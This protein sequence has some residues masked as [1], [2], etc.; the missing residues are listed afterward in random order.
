M[1]MLQMG[2]PA[3]AVTGEQQAVKQ[4]RDIGGITSLSQTQLTISTFLCRVR[5][6]P[7]LV[8]VFQRNQISNKSYHDI[9]FSAGVTYW[10]YTR[11]RL[12]RYPQQIARIASSIFLQEIQQIIN[13]LN[14]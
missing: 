11:Q 12:G 4:Y 1:R 10:L 2:C 13:T 8:Q 5:L 3:V 9:N 6:L 7:R 14:Q